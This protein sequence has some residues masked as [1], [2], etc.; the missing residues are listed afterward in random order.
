VQTPFDAIRL[1]HMTKSKLIF[2]CMA[3]NDQKI[4]R[5][6]SRRRIT[7]KPGDKACNLEKL[8]PIHGLK[9]NELKLSFNRS[10]LVEMTQCAISI[11]AAR[12]DKPVWKMRFI[13][14]IKIPQA[15]LES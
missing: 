3:T 8:I 4:A 7:K 2:V 15:L 12:N 13:R 6:V 9:R 11:A 1:A 10:E 5:V 14:W